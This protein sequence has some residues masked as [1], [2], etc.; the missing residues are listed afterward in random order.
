MK[1]KTGYETKKYRFLS[2]FRFHSIFAKTFFVQ[3]VLTFAV[4]GLSFMFV[5]RLYAQRY[6]EQTFYAGFSKLGAASEEL[7]LSID[8]L[9]VKMQNIFQNS[10][11]HRIIVNGEVTKSLLALNTALK[12][13]DLVQQEAYAKSAWLYLAQGDSII[14]SD[15]AIVSRRDSPAASI[16]GVYAAQVQKADALPILLKIRGNL[17]LF[18]SFPRGKTLATLCVLLDSEALSEALKGDGAQAGIYAYYNGIPLFDRQM[19]Y[20]EESACRITGRE[21]VGGGRSVCKAAGNAGYFLTYDSQIENLTL[22]LQVDSG[23]L[24]RSGTGVL[25]FMVPFFL[26]V[27]VFLAIAS[28]YL[29]KCVYRPIQRVIL[30]MTGHPN[31]RLEYAPISAANELEL[32]ENLH[33]ESERQRIALS[34]MLNAVGNAV[35]KKLFLAVIKQKETNE[36]KA[37]EILKQTGSPFPLEGQYLVLLLHRVYDM[38]KR[39]METEKELQK[40]LLARISTAY[41]QEKGQICVLDEKENQTVLVLCFA[42]ECSAASIKHWMQEF[43]EQ[44]K[45]E[46][47]AEDGFLAVGAGRLYRRMMD[48]HCAYQ[49]AENNLQ[50]RLYYANGEKKEPNL[51]TAYRC[52]AGEI[53]DKTVRG[54]QAEPEALERLVENAAQQPEFA[55]KIYRMMADLLLEELLHFNVDLKKGWLEKRKTLETGA[56]C[57]SGEDPRPQA[58]KVFCREALEAI[59]GVAGKEQF[60]HLENARKYIAD[61]YSERN[62]SMYSVSRACGISSSYLS[63]LFVAYQPPGFVEYL[64]RYRLEKAKALM[65]TTHYTIADIGFK[66]GFNSPQNFIRVFKKYDGETPGQFRARHLKEQK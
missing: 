52:Q 33:H 49:D 5:N 36:G 21:D 63:R 64:N 30:S 14:S 25:P 10:D 46:M 1:I 57:L 28:L 16:F 53:L 3:F 15:K 8:S 29:V 50:E 39:P 26:A 24:S 35:T 65:V 17:Y 40:I 38:G 22:M 47:A 4:L 2:V 55:V 7:N 12:L 27:L 43:R 9:T 13:S 66:T 18:S 62:L 48:L 31:G 61:H 56:D 6:R 51:I 37:R 54:A 41:W 23:I 34:G 20:P 58:M 60:R 11:C 19:A 44:V 42:P 59:A 32:I 45:G